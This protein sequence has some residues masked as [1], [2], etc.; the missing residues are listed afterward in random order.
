M[1]LLHVILGVALAVGAAPAPGD[2]TRVVASSRLGEVTAED[3]ERFAARR[4]DG[5]SAGLDDRRRLLE[6]LL[7]ERAAVAEAERLA[8]AATPEV[9]A[10]LTARREA[11]L[12][13]EMRSRLESAANVAGVDEAAVE[14]ALAR[15]V[16]RSAGGERLRLR[17]LFK[18][19]PANASPEERRTIEAAMQEMLAKLRAGADFAA[20]ARAHSDSQTAPFGGLIAPIAR[21]DVDPSLVEVLWG[22]APGE[23]TGVVETPLGLHVFRLEE[24]VSAPAI[25]SEPLREPVRRELEAAAR[26]AAL[27]SDFDALLR[28]SAAEFHPALLEGDLRP[29]AS[30][31][32]RLFALGGAQVTGAD[33]LEGWRRLSFGARRRTSLRSRLEEEAGRRLLLWDAD[34]RGI[35]DEPEVAELLGEARCDVLVGAAFER[36]LE[37][38]APCPPRDGFGAGEARA[39]AN[40]PEARRLRG[41][42]VRLAPERSVHEVYDELDLVARAV[43]AGTQDLAAAAR[44]LSQDASRF[45]DGDL[46]WAEAKDLAAWAGV[47]VAPAVFALAAGEVSPPLL[48]EEYDAGRLRDEPTAYLIVRVEEIRPAGALREEAAA[49]LKA[50]CREHRARRFASRLRDDFLAF[51]EAAVYEDRL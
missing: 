10:Q 7:V 20:L 39:P 17:H 46:G 19:L 42:L 30:L 49:E 41:I 25:D 24:R 22:L 33:L 38:L 1:N 14:A 27:K 35:E 44:R 8:L 4:G 18:R 40:A 21:E 3:L 48:V 23:S 37:E 32:Q 51:I 43:R 29:T 13:A 11:I 26:Q 50:R 5:G 9:A 34:R 15:R 16:A 47:R 28:R 2:E 12:V 36:R 6:R 45:A 31:S